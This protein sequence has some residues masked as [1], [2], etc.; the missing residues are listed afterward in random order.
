MQNLYLIGNRWKYRKGIPE[1][2]R[3]HIDGQI[4]EFVRWLG[5]HEGQGKSPLPKITDRYSEAA[6]ECASL[7][8]MAEKRASDHF[9]DLNP[10]TIAHIIAVARHE[11]MDEDEAGRFAP[12]VLNYDKHWEKRQ[13]SIEI[14][15]AVWKHEYARGQ[16]GEFVVDEVVDRC[17]A[18]GLRVDTT[19]DGFRKLARAYLETLIAT[20]E[21]ARK[22]QQGEPV[23]TP[24]PPPPIAAHAV[25]K[26]ITQTITGLAEDWW[27]EGERTGLSVSTKEAYTRAARQ[28]SDFLG[29]D[30]ANAVT[31]ADIV[32]F[33]D[34]RLEQGKSAKTVKMG[35]LSA[36]NAL[37]TWGVDNHRVASHPGT[38]KLK[39][40]KKTKTR[41]KGFT[42]D[43]AT[44][45]LSAATAYQPTGKEPDQI[46][47]AKRW[48]PW[49]LAYTGAR[50]GEMA[51]LRR[52]DVRHE[53]GRW[54]IRLTPEAGTIK[55]DE[56]R[57]VVIHPHLV[58]LGFP[59][60]I[61]KAKP[62]HLFL[63]ITRKGPEG[64]MGALQT[65]KNRI[66]NFVRTVITD[67][68][69]QPNHAWRHRF[70]TTARNLGK[71]QDVTNAITGHSAKDVAGDYGE[72][73][74]AAQEEFFRNWPRFQISRPPEAN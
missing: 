17:A 50:V 31:N 29:H 35:D 46:T 55:T 42:D 43:E 32:R 15:L 33:K 36:L 67:M 22:R 52:E 51:Q 20:A 72:D 11:L 59:A 7:I 34:F 68:R 4:T 40:A 49:L 5:A 25:H 54:I 60:F 18:M 38:V 44:A 64:V 26:P 47:E 21:G 69:V 57:D 13:E 45:L 58:D 66:T 8:A 12:D 41:P 30:D 73:E 28:F 63:K 19:S 48:V 65:T 74:M 27:K 61:E 16:I 23:P 10:E 24:A 70:E 1:R 39:V 2:L 62:G 6:R 53:N 56:Y 9:D 14:S 71:R 37:F 3:P